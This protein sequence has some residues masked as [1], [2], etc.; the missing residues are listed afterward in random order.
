[1]TDN[2]ELQ[3]QLRDLCGR[4]HKNV[5]TVC[6][7]AITIAELERENAELRQKVSD[8]G[9]LG[10]AL[11]DALAAVRVGLRVCH[12]A[13]ETIDGICEAAGLDVDSWRAARAAE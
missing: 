9:E 1:M 5:C 13:P 10:S 7:A 12:V 2:Y 3:S 6:E 11:S 8:A 4:C